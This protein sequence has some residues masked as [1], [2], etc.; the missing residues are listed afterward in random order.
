MIARN[1][2]ENIT[3]IQEFD[4]E[5][6]IIPNKGSGGITFNNSISDFNSVLTANMFK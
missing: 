1:N 4:I 5:S 3:G 2:I 6:A